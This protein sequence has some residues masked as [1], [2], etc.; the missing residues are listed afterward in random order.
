MTTSQ[1]HDCRGRGRQGNGPEDPGKG[2]VPGDLRE[3]LGVLG[4]RGREV[5]QTTRDPDG[6]P[7]GET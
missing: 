6:N 1:S 5:G 3:E 4:K 2:E 7:E